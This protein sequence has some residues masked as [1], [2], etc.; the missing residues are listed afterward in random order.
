MGLR[1]IFPTISLP[2]SFATSLLLAQRNWAKSEAEYMH[3]RLGGKVIFRLSVSKLSFPSAGMWAWKLVPYPFGFP[4]RVI[5][6]CS[7]RCILWR[8][9]SC[10]LKE[11]NGLLYM[12]SRFLARKKNGL[13]G[14]HDYQGP[15]PSWVWQVFSNA[16][17]YC[18]VCLPPVIT[19]LW[20]PDSNSDLWFLFGINSSFPAPFA[21]SETAPQSMNIG[22]RRYLVSVWKT[23]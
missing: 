5:E 11:N 14:F 2:G 3:E 12:L 9:F 8:I 23:K 7:L 6:L 16:Q 15:H 13:A 20:K 17:W 21:S 18:R 1:S 22:S 4:S 10:E 19:E